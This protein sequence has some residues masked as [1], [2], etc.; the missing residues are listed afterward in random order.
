[1][2]KL[3]DYFFKIICIFPI[4]TAC[5]NEGVGNKVL[6]T[7]LIIL[8][9]LFIFKG[10]ITKRFFV[11]TVVVAVVYF[12]SLF[13]TDFPISNTNMLF[14]FPFFI[15]YSALMLDKKEMFMNWCLINRKYINFVLI[16]WS[17]IVGISIFLPS[18]YYI[19]EG[20]A[21]YFGSFCGT[22]FRLGPSSVFIQGLSIIGM[23]FFKNKKYI[24]FMIIPL[25]CYFM[26]SSRTYLIV[27]ISL[28]TIAWYWYGAKKSVFY[29]TLIPLIA[30]GGYA[31]MG[32]SL[33]T[34]ILYTLDE[35]QYGDFW[36]RLTSSRSLFWAKDINAF[37]QAGIF[38]KL[39][40][41]GIEFTSKLT[42]L[43]AHND[44][45]EIICSYG[46][47][48]LGHYLYTNYRIIKLS[49]YSKKN[50]VPLP[51]VAM[52]YI[53]WLFNAFFNMHFTYFCCVLSFPMICIAVG[54]KYKENEQ[55]V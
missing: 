9:L 24:F 41:L 3:I 55:N 18:C 38:G 21:S 46:I 10:K 40:G 28:F 39:L 17:V 4:Y 51:I 23:T 8:F 31:L 44:F 54:Y 6:F 13:N 36:Y 26:G 45:I 22:I 20:G 32:S 5:V 19:K 29:C 27:G 33:G 25:Y 2:R 35:S 14:Y 12:Y 49:G 11:N 34:K 37:K 43:W 30:L 1:M 7:L 15:E 52:L 50:N 48:G 16:I 53:A 42:G 47:I